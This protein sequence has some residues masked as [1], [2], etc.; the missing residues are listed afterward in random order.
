MLYDDST[1]VPLLKSAQTKT[2]STANI[3]SHC[4]RCAVDSQP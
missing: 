1:W 4:R 3:F 2:F